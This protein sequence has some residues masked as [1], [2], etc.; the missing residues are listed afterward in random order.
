MLSPTKP[1]RV[2]VIIECKNEETHN[3]TYVIGV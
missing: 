1:T 2:V 3:H